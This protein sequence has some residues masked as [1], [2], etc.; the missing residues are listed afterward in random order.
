MVFLTL[1]CG[2]RKLCA[3]LNSGFVSPLCVRLTLCAGLLV[4][5]VHIG[6]CLSTLFYLYNSCSIDSVAGL[7]LN[8]YWSVFAYSG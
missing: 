4:I 5:S 6:P 3:G 2:R 7:I 1:R 8:L